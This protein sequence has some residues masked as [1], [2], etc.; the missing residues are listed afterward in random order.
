MK[1]T[2]LGVAMSAAIVLGTIWAY[3]KFLKKDIAALGK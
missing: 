1:S 2:L 3:Q